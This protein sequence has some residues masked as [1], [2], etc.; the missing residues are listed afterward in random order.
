VKQD[1]SL[2][3]PVY[4]WSR[5]QATSSS[6]T[7]TVLHCRFDGEIITYLT[8]GDELT[9]NEPRGFCEPSVI[10]YEGR[11]YLTLRNDV[12]G[13]VTRGGD[14]LHFEPPRPWTFDDGTE[15]GSYNTQQ[16]WLTHAGALY[17]V[18]TRRGADNDD[19][20]RHRA[21]LFIARV[22][23]ERLCVLRETERVVVPNRGAT[24][25]NFGAVRI[26]DDECWV[27]VA[28]GMFFPD[29][30]R[31]HGATGAVWVSRIR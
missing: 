17:L 4:G 2:L 28:E 31:K 12:R 3:V 10:E 25:G 20:F 16:H 11:Y 9:I 27:T 22:D 14:G 26:S 19:I 1:G 8:H 6:A 24:L 7:A 18:Y 29:V 5:E 15:L 21:P 13:Y 30:Y 23:P